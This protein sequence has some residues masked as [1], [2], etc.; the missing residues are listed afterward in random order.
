MAPELQQYTAFMVG[1]PGF[2]EFTRM[3]FGQCSTP[4]TFK[5]LM[6]NTLGELN[7]TYCIIYLDDVIVFRQLKEEHLEHLC[8][9]FEHFQEFNLKLKPAKCSFQMER[10]YLVHLVSCEGI[11]PSKENVCTYEEFPIPETHTQ[12]RVFCG[13]DGHHHHFIKGFTLL[14][15]PQY[16]ILGNKVKMGPVMLPLEAQDVV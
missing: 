14:A 2:Y 8:V 4:A 10:I 5:C 16:N 15:H 1:N 7:L 12:V 3:P 6:Q 13:L 9:V 11:H